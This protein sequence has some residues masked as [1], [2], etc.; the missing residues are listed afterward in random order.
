[1]KA[2][3]YLKYAYI[4]GGYGGNIYLMKTQRMKANGYCHHRN[5]VMQ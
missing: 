1:M 5:G 4:N 3:L 2:Q